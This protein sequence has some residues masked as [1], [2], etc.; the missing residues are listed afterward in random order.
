MSFSIS[1]NGNE[2]WVTKSHRALSS[3]SNIP[4]FTQQSWDLKQALLIG[5]RH[6]PI[7]QNN[8][9]DPSTGDVAVQADLA[10]TPL[11]GYPVHYFENAH[12]DLS[13]AVQMV[14]W[15]SN[16]GPG[17]NLTFDCKFTLVDFGSRATANNVPASANRL[18]QSPQGA[19]PEFAFAEEWDGVANG[20]VYD[21]GVINPN[22][23]GA[24]WMVG[25]S[26]NQLEYG[27]AF[28]LPP[29]G[30][31]VLH[32]FDAPDLVA[33]QVPTEIER[34]QISFFCFMIDERNGQSSRYA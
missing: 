30:P 13:L 18:N 25:Q 5:G 4:Y 1:G 14:T 28:I 7:P 31:G 34:T 29:K 11:N 27:G 2:Q 33:A 22:A 6:Y 32:I 26:I 12:P 23:V 9:D 10:G 17:R 24:D 19:V 8:D 20:M 3:A 15:G 16:G 21:A